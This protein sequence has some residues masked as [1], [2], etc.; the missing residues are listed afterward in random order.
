MTISK[1]DLLISKMNT[2]LTIA[3]ESKLPIPERIVT[4]E[5]EDDEEEEDTEPFGIALPVS[6]E[7]M[8]FPTI[9]YLYILKR[10]YLMHR[11]WKYRNFEYV[12]G[13]NKTHRSWNKVR[14]IVKYDKYPSI[15][16]MR[17]SHWDWR[18]SEVALNEKSIR[19]LLEYEQLDKIEE[20]NIGAWDEDVSDGAKK[21]I[22]L[23]VNH[24][25]KL[26]HI[27]SI[28]LADMSYQSSEVSWINLGDV[29]DLFDKYTN[30]MF[31]K[32]KGM[33]NLVINPIQ[34]E[35]LL[36]I[37]LVTG[38]LEKLILKS[39]LQSQLPNLYHLEL[40]VGT[41]GYGMDINVEMMEQLFSKHD[42]GHFPTLEYLGIRN[43]EDVNLI[44]G[45]IAESAI[46]AR[47]R[48][49]D[50]SLG[51]IEAQGAKELLRLGERNDL[52]LEVLDLHHNGLD[53]TPEM[54]KQLESLP[55]I[56]NVGMSNRGNRYIAL[57]E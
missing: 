48:I 8:I 10:R 32:S 18:A 21:I 19:Q 44:C 50:L 33:C 47:I 5:N 41:A 52:M 46:V 2:A 31:W 29:T 40:W 17:S 57:S 7:G 25:N 20:V 26:K 16:P 4:D 53:K 35:M 24:A 6:A 30:M 23:L 49:L 12:Q 27:K 43:Y 22:S 38:G 42:H 55:M 3:K 56:V 34:S 37:T 13:E 39:L 15:P 36:S 1:L 28:T 9:D 14:P 45:L 54:K 51:S 11:Y